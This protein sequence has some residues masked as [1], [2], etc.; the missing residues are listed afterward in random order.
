LS[1][2]ENQY[3]DDDQDKATDAYIHVVLLELF[4]SMKRISTFHD[5]TA[6]KPG[7]FDSA[8]DLCINRLLTFI[9]L[10]LPNVIKTTR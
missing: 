7:L 4:G 10:P 5:K 3:Q 6:E 1:S 8:P 9:P 2:G